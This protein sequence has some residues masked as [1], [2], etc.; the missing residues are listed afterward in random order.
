M[1]RFTEPSNIPY[2]QSLLACITLVLLVTPVYFF[3]YG[4]TY[5]AGF[6]APLFRYQDT[7]LGSFLVFFTNDIYQVLTGGYQ[8]MVAYSRLIGVAGTCLMIASVILLVFDRYTRG[9]GTTFSGV[10]VIIS[11]WV[12]LVS[13][14]VHYGVLFSGPSGTAFP[15]G[16]PLFLLV[17]YWLYQQG[18]IRAH[19][20]NIP[21]EG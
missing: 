14:I 13:I 1:I 8:G 6:Q 11:A 17:G 20:W 16:I 12:Y 2:R 9:M 18:K 4:Q 19:A 15:V 10:L 3:N 7:M 21:G 5:G